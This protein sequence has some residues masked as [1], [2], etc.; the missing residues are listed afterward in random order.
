MEG[1]RLAVYGEHGAAG[2]A[3]FATPD[4]IWRVE[5]AST[6]RE[7]S[8]KWSSALLGFEELLPLLCSTDTYSYDYATREL[9]ELRYSSTYDRSIITET[10][11]TPQHSTHL[12]SFTMFC[13]CSNLHGT[14]V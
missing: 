5:P 4:T 13:N 11:T 9:R 8:R 6:P 3:Q 1:E 14:K 10:H 12:G 2:L 7:S